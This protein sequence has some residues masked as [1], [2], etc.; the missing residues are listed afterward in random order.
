MSHT[1]AGTR[2]LVGAKPGSEVSVSGKINS[3]PGPLLPTVA[4]LGGSCPPA[5]L[6]RAAWW[7]EGGRGL[8]CGESSLLPPL[9][10][11][12][13]LASRCGVG[14]CGP[15][16]RQLCPLPAGTPLTQ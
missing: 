2:D 5:S 8:G 16:S 11:S 14:L 13:F 7:L 3:A 4:S 6:L 1:G 9:S 12:A 15:F 10:C